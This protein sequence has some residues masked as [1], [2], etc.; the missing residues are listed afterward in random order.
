MPN[1]N[2]SA[3]SS[4]TSATCSTDVRSTQWPPRGFDLLS[5]P[6][7]WLTNRTTDACAGHMN[8]TF[9]MTESVPYPG[10]LGNGLLPDGHLPLP[11]G[12]KVPSQRAVYT[13]GGTDVDLS[14]HGCNDHSQRAT[15]DRLVYG[16]GRAARREGY[17]CLHYETVVTSFLSLGSGQDDYQGAH[18]TPQLC[19]NRP[20]IP[21]EL[22]NDT[23]TYVHRGDVLLPLKLETHFGPIFEAAL[24]EEAVRASGK[25]SAFSSRS[26]VVFW[27]GQDSFGPGNRAVTQVACNGGHARVDTSLKGRGSPGD[28]YRTGLPHECSL[29]QNMMLWANMSSVPSAALSE[30]NRL[31]NLLPGKDSRFD[32]VRRWGT[33]AALKEG[34]DVAFNKVKRVDVAINHCASSGGSNPVHAHDLRV[35]DHMTIEA[36]V[37]FKYLVVVSG[38]DKATNLNWVLWTDSVPLMSPPAD[39]SWLCEGW[40]E[41]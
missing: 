8:Y 1:N 13:F 25:D 20:V 27:R 15:M 17:E 30:C 2:R 9:L 16:I 3:A 21:R 10:V 32:L 34:I 24:A 41:P 28:F 4:T 18:V 29:L 23:V 36:M 7:G 38:M 31:S 11:A 6:R 26:D 5:G 37:Q 40:L 22:W 35:A 14:A 33:S 12:I 39:E 19:K